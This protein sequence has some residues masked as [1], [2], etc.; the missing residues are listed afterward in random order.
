MLKNAHRIFTFIIVA[1]ILCTLLPTAVLAT[2]SLD[3]SDIPDDAWYAADMAKAVGMKT[4]RGDGTDRLRPEDTITRQEAFAVLTRAFK[5][6][7]GDPAAVI[8]CI[9][10]LHQPRGIRP[11]HV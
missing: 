7:E 9:Y 10:R 5:L 8:S 6:P 3:F 2:E 4:F 11:D 1:A